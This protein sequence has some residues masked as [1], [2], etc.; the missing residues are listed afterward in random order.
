MRKTDAFCSNPGLYEELGFPALQSVATLPSIAHLLPSKKQGHRCG[1]YLLAFPDNTHYIGQA[2]EVVRR[3]AQHRQNHSI[4]GFS[5]IRI[6][7]EKLNKVEIEKIKLAEALGLRLT[8]IVHTTVIAGETDLD[9]VLPLEEQAKW[10][11]KGAYYFR[12]DQS[13]SVVL[14]EAHICKFAKKIETFLAHPHADLAIDLLRKYL[15]NFIPSPRLTEY[16]FW[17]VSCMPSTGTADLKRLFCVSAASME[18]FVLFCGKTDPKDISGFLTVSADALEEMIPVV[19][20]FR[21]RHPS[22]EFSI[23][24]YRDAGEDQVTLHVWGAEALQ[25]LVS[26][27]VVQIAGGILAQR[28][29]RKRPTF[30][31]QYHCPQLA[32]LALK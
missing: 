24:P 18:L 29:M 10:I 2:I 13:P 28:V 31:A 15:I 32:R 7:P 26:D 4:S 6:K 9:L 8:N 30:Y 20:D 19:D 21:E 23:Y 5:F 14:P 16:S 11:G 1:V 17:N 22:V 25:W 12:K 3:F 27:E